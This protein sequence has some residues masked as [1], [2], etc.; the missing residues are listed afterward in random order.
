M[1]RPRTGTKFFDPKTRRWFVVVTVDLKGG[2]T[3]RRPIQLKPGTTEEEAER[4]RIEWV[5]KVKGRLF[6]P[7]ITAP[8]DGD[9]LTVKEYV[10]NRWLPSREKRGLLSVRKDR[11]RYTQ[12]VNPLIG[13]KRMHAVTDDD[14]RG[15]VETLDNKVN[16]GEL[17]WRTAIFIWGIVAKVFKDAV[18]SKEALLRVLKE[19]PCKDVVG[20]DRGHDKAKQWLYPNEFMQLINCADVPLEWRRVYALTIYLYMRLGEVRAL[21][22]SDIDLSAGMVMV[23]RSTDELGREVREFTKSRSVRH[24]KIEPNLLP[25]LKVMIGA[26]ES[27]PLVNMRLKD[28]PAFLREHLTKANVKRVALHN[29]TETSLPIRFHDLRATGITWAALRGDS[30]LAIR[31]RAGHADVEQTNDY[32]RRAS[33]AGSVGEPFP[34]L[35]ILCRPPSLVSHSVSESQNGQ[36]HREVLETAGF[37]ESLDGEHTSKPAGDPVSRLDTEEHELTL[38]SVTDETDDAFTEADFLAALAESCERAEV[39][40]LLA[41]PLMKVAPRVARK[42]ARGG[43][44]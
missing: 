44:K 17:G 7:R 38:S 20:P 43:A 16:E 28:A 22:V 1:G 4:K 24:F 2:G 8:R 13:S 32:M 25:L 14:L 39:A 36:L 6:D 41:R 10:E 30:T 12:H 21:D 18:S 15:V 9:E 34:S 33:A 42:L 37:T 5:Q 19:N 29:E 23:H 27:G 40:E 35:D 31:D 26:R 11:Q 3:D